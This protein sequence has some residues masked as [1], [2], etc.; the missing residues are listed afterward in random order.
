MSVL[1][2]SA[3]PGTVT[4]ISHN[5]GLNAYSAAAI[6]FLACGRRYLQFRW[7]FSSDPAQN[8]RASISRHEA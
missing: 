4:A 6:S 7:R 5:D 1:T 8:S 3:L 2:G